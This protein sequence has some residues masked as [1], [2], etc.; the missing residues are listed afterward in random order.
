MEIRVC[1]RCAAPVPDLP[2]LGAVTLPQADPATQPRQVVGPF[3]VS[4]AVALPTAG[5]D[6]CS[7]CLVSA[8]V[9]YALVA[10]KDVLTPKIARQLQERIDQALGFVV[11]AE[12]TSGV[13]GGPV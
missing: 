10:M 8:F 4:L 2:A 9:E 6:L 1:N 11:R 5:V 13:S 7:L 3:V 12:A